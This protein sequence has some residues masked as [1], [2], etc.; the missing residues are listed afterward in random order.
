MSAFLSAII[1]G[2]FNAM[3]L[4]ANELEDPFGMEPNDICMMDFHYEFCALLQGLLP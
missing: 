4:V 2:S 3:W 1:V